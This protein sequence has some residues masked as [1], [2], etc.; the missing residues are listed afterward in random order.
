[1][2]KK[3]DTVIF[4]LDGTLADT[5]QDLTEGMNYALEKMG[6][7]T[8]SKEQAKQAVGPGKEEFVR[9]LFPGEENPDTETF[10]SFFRERHWDCCLNQ[11]RLYPG[12]ESVLE[13]LKD[14]NLTVA[15]NKPIRF[16]EKIL[17]GLDVRS[18]FDFTIGAD[19]VA[20]AK[21][22][23]EMI[24]RT[25]K[26]MKS[27]PERTLFIG[28]TANDMQAGRSAGV[29]LCGVRYGYGDQSRVMDSNPDFHIE[30]PLELLGILCNNH[31][32]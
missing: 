3:Y 17:I 12:M 21:P 4:D 26:E 10:V 28:D 27:S 8:V 11:T 13:K 22:H 18:E 9:A 5:L 16:V 25:L 29:G 20:Q 14:L 7:Q 1:M 30:K 32:A 15:S 31:N 24:L 6:Y 19:E 23:P 2:K